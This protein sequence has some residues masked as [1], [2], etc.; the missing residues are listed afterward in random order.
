MPSRTEYFGYKFT[1]LGPLTTTY[2][3]P[4]SCTTATTDRI[5]F[6]NA[7]TLGIGYGSARCD[8]PETV[9]KCYPSG[10]TYDSL[11][12]S[13]ATYHDQGLLRYFSP[14]VACPKGWTTAGTLA[15]GEKTDSAEKAGVFTTEPFPYPDYMMEPEQI[16]VNV[17]EPLETL[18]YC[19]P[20]YLLSPFHSFGHHNGSN[21]CAKRLGI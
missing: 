19:C 12:S 11:L 7:K 5:Y 8:G 6:A 13:R 14:G 18:A 10:A 16:W 21:A 2:E 15:H 1:N 9:G 20:R 4:A 3:P 17:L